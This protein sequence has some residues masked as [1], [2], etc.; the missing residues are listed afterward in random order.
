MTGIGKEPGT[1]LTQRDWL[2]A[3]VLFV[4]L[5]SLYFAT[6][7]GITSSND[8]SHYALTRTMAENHAFA[9]MQFD[10]YAEGND[11]AIREEVLYSD[12]PP[13]TAVLSTIFY[14]LGN[15]LP[16]PISQLP[17]RHDAENQRL[18][19]VM[20]LP[21]LAGAGTAVLLYLFLR[22]HGVTMAGAVTTV[23]MFSLGTAQWKYST[24]LF[25]HA[26]SG[27]LV[28][29]AI[30]LT[31][32]LTTKDWQL[33]SN[34]WPRY[35]LLGFVLGFSVL[36]E[37]SNGLLVVLVS[38]FVF[39]RLSQWKRWWATAVPFAIGGLIPAAFLAYYDTI[40]FGSPLTLSYA[41]AVNYPWAGNFSST[42]SW[43]LLPG[44]QALLVWGEG[45][46]WCN[47]TC[48]NQGIFLLSPIM[49]L[50]LPGFW[51]YFRRARRPFW[52]TTAV[53]LVYLLLFAK[54]FTSHGFTGDGRYLVPF[55]SLLA[56]PLA[57]AVDWLLNPQQNSL[58]LAGIA[59]IVYG[60][61][62]LS[63]RNILLHIGFSYNYHL[64]LSQLSPMIAS[65]QNWRYLVNTLFP[66]RGN[67]PLL[68]LLQTVAG[69]VGILWLRLRKKG[70]SP[71]FSEKSE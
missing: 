57:Y 32:R 46:G 33:K 41:F 10:D 15:L 19:Y 43:P 37:Y 1:K 8:G 51:L 36:V 22:Q 64:D 6:V 58:R 3:V 7:S 54:H 52:L 16:D 50:A 63:L 21:V 14:T 9:L 35:L 49:L 65:P 61:F 66:N 62:F 11:I 56:I 39:G 60:L 31:T 45:G 53:F 24:V 13:G 40:N 23:L 48:Y 71:T 67:L 42:F 47:P 2:V 12:R 25:S 28:L 70:N 20:L 18:L 34:L 38:L 69:L 30:F 59:F 26:L 68:W 5:S 29:L 4:G 17:S 55:L 44:L 27:F